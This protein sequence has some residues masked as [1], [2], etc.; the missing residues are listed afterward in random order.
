MSTWG[1]MIKRAEGEN[2]KDEEFS[3]IYYDNDSAKKPIETVKEG[4]Y[5]SFNYTICTAGDY[6]ILDIRTDGYGLS[7]FSG[8][9]LVVLKF[10]DG[11][12][13]ELDRSVLNKEVTKYLYEFNKEG[14]YI[15]SKRNEDGH[16]YTV[17]EVEKYAEMFIDKIIQCE[18][19]SVKHSSMSA[20][21]TCD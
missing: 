14:D 7:V 10:P 5:K 9:N 6:P 12:W 3:L 18:E 13:F 1:D 17:Q 21:T 20:L 15:H 8:Y 2:I 4:K 16:K 19:E 11:K